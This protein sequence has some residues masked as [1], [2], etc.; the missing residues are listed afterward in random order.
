[1]P[2]L[3][4]HFKGLDLIEM[5]SI[6]IDKIQRNFEPL[7]RQIAAWQS[8]AMEDDRAKLI[9]YAAFVEGRLAAPAPSAGDP[10]ALLPAGVRGVPAANSLEPLERLH[11]GVQRTQDDPPVPSDRQA[12]GVPGA[13]RRGAQHQ[14]T[15]HI[16]GQEFLPFLF[17]I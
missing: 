3:H 17:Q 10:P 11:I 8:D 2:V 12:G 15:A 7:K 13:L 4:K 9:L 6:G 16:T 1:M 14:L 5:V